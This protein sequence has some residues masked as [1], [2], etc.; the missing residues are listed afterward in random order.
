MTANIVVNNIEVK[1]ALETN[2]PV[3]NDA[4]IS[5]G[6]EMKKVDIYDQQE[7]RQSSQD[8]NNQQ[9]EQHQNQRSFDEEKAKRFARYF[10]YNTREYTA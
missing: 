10:G 6:I 2:M 8:S 4:F 9:F 3:L 1:K 7:Q 5:R